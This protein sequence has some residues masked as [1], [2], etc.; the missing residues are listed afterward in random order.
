MIAPLA[1][2]SRSVTAAVRDTPAGRAEP[3]RGLSPA[4]PPV[5]A[6]EL[7]ERYHAAYERGAGDLPAG[8][9]P[10]ERSIALVATAIPD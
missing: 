1:T 4:R 5:A 10:P 8:E 3:R 7:A 9:E 6:D 2:A